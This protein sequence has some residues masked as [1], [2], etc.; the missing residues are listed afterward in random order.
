MN[1]QEPTYSQRER[2]LP[3]AQY[4]FTMIEV[5]VTVFILSVG[6]LGVAGM[7]AVAVRESQNTYYRTQADILASDIVDRMR[8]NRTE[9]YGGT[10]NSYTDAPAGVAEAGCA[11]DCSADEMAAYDLAQWKSVIDNSSLP[12]GKGTISW[13][14]DV[15][16]TDGSTIGSVYTIQV[17]W[18]ENRDGSSGENCDPSDDADMSC[19][20]LVVQI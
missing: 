7:Q 14:S 10:N 5:M 13:N 18:D 9:A 20:R 17:F 11:N 4:G 6:I 3:V 1:I 12:A 16:G 8:A 15:V 19:I 2:R